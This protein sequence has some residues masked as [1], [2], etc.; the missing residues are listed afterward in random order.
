MFLDD[1]YIEILPFLNSEDILMKKSPEE[2]I[3]ILKKCLYYRKLIF[4]QQYQL[5]KKEYLFIVLYNQL[6]TKGQYSLK[7]DFKN[8]KLG[9]TKQ[10]NTELIILTKTFFSNEEIP[11][12]NKEESF[13]KVTYKNLFLIFQKFFNANDNL[14]KISQLAFS[15]RDEDILNFIFKNKKD[16][17]ALI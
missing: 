2:K 7:T 16:V 5:L 4:K 8:N 10:Q 14:K 13:N 9:L 12:L 6:D 15:L 1:V 11:G 17:E 3:E